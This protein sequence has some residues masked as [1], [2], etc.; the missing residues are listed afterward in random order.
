ML[1]G[2]LYHLPVKRRPTTKRGAS[3][4]ARF[5]PEE[6][7]LLVE[8]KK[9]GLPWQDVDV[10]PRYHYGELRLSR[11]NFYAPFLFGK[12]NFQKPHGQYSDYFARFYGPVLFGFA[13]ASTVLN[14]MQVEMADEQVS[15]A[16]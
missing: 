14:S 2:T 8:P 4:R 5:T 16:H 1:L 10:S 7:D 15:A 9:Q 11:L 13:V 6:G 12:F 3:T